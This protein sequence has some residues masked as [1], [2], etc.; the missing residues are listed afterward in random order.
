MFRLMINTVGFET[1]ISCL[2]PRMIP[3]GKLVSLPEIPYKR[4]AEQIVI[5]RL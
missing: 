1:S 5:N 4:H 3:N 2:G